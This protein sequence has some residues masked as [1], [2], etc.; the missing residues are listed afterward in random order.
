MVS[1]LYKLPASTVSAIP[2][3]SIS[4]IVAI[5]AWQ[6]YVGGG[7]STLARQAKTILGPGKLTR[8]EEAWFFYAPTDLGTKEQC[9][10]HRG[11]GLEGEV[12]W[13]VGSVEE[14][15]SRED[16][17]TTGGTEGGGR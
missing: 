8:R 15:E 13:E 11:R 7:G 10:H 9:I 3:D 12:G 4:A 1:H 16:G 6:W 2:S 17:G 5:S 14:V